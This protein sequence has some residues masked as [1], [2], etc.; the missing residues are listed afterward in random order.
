MARP[1][2]VQSPGRSSQAR[3]TALSRTL[4][5]PRAMATASSSDRIRGQSLRQLNRERFGG[6]MSSSCVWSTALSE[7]MRLPSIVPSTTMPARSPGRRPSSRKLLMAVRPRVS[8]FAERCAMSN[9]NTNTRGPSGRTGVTTALGAGGTATTAARLPA[10][11][12]IA[13]SAETRES[14]SMRWRSPRSR[15]SKS[16]AVSVVTGRPSRSRTVTSTSTRSIPARNCGVCP[17]PCG[18]AVMA[19]AASSR[20]AAPAALLLNRRHDQGELI[21]STAFKIRQARA[22][23]RPGRQDDVLRAV[24]LLLVARHIHDDELA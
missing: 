23:V 21:A 4:V 17:P 24:D 16:A 14:V 6:E 3:W 11:P 8:P 19:P 10:R 22:V 18:A 20:A 12:R 1:L 7:T 15:T 9:T 2:P 13:G 5:S